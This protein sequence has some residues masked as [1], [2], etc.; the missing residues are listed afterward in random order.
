MNNLFML[1]KLKLLKNNLYAIKKIEIIF[2]FL[3]VFFILFSAT[4]LK[5][6]WNKSIDMTS[7]HALAIAKSSEIALNGEMLKQL[8][9]LPEDVGTTAY[10]SIKKRLVEIPSIDINIRFAYIYT[11][12]DSKIYFL[13]DS[14]PVSSSDYSPPG[15]EFTEANF[16]IFEPLKTGQPLI[17][18]PATDRWG[19]WVSVLVPVKDSETGQVKAV[20]GLDYP[21]KYWTNDA[22]FN[23]SLSGIFILALFLLLFLFYRIIK[24]NL[25]TKENEKR[26]SNVI[27]GIDAGIWEWNIQTGEMIFNKKWA[28]IIGYKLEE[29]K[30]TSI[31][32]WDSFMYPDDLKKSKELLNLHFYKKSENYSFECRL[33]HRSGSWVW[34]SDQGKVTEWSK[35]DK[36]LRMFGTRIDINKRKISEEFV[37]KTLDDSERLNKLM[38]GR[39]LEMIKQK[40]EIQE[41]KD[42]LSHS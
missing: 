31:K 34:V 30:P 29:L 14:E 22:I 17:T 32:T 18:K 5:Y 23:T 26:F 21:S 3:T 6:T 38:I 42:K 15:Q 41:L 12:K 40:K 27:L 19:N 36:P 33:R 39:E 7:Y 25:K 16:E 2:L 28:E 13:A 1:N 37:S 8:H 4:Y 35:D 11:Q 9:A 10:E 24:N 20:F